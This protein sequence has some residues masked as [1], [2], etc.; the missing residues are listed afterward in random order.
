LASAELSAIN[1]ALDEVVESEEGD[2]EEQDVTTISSA[3]TDAVDQGKTFVED[4]V[5]PLNT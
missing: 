2:Y 4:S 3:V 5:I 1:R